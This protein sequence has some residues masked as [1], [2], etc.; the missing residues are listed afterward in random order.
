ME[1]QTAIIAATNLEAN[2]RLAQSFRLE[3]GPV[4]RFE[5]AASQ[6]AGQRGRIVGVEPLA[7]VAAQTH[8]RA[9][10]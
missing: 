7:P 6:L 8:F 5:V 9:R 10:Q 4:E 1:R 3:P 2:W